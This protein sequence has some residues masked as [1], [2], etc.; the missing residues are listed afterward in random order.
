[1][2]AIGAILAFVTCRAAQPLC[3]PG[4]GM[5]RYGLGGTGRVAGEDS[6][7]GN[8]RL[9]IGPVDETSYSYR[10]SREDRMGPASGREGSERDEGLSMDSD[11]AMSGHSRRGFGM[12]S[13]P[14]LSAD[15]DPAHPARFI[16]TSLAEVPVLNRLR[17]GALGPGINL[18][19]YDGVGFTFEL[20]RVG[21]SAP[22]RGSPDSA[23]F[24]SMSYRF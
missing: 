14:D 7:A 17:F 5:S 11:P 18:G 13:R 23:A 16:S 19:T 12:R 2:L 20:P 6:P 8:L 10:L 4:P 21:R 15:R 24:L 22:L 3:E 1:M 9:Q